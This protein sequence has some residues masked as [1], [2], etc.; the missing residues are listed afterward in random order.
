M[1]NDYKIPQSPDYS[2]DFQENFMYQANPEYI[3]REIAGEYILV[4]TG[5]ELEN[6]NGLAAVNETG[7][8]LWKLLNEK[9]TFSEIVECFQKEFELTREESWNDVSEFM[10]LAVKGR[11]ILKCS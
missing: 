11:V 4:P 3:M 8:F 5:A 9:K 1:K 6:F 7:V 10:D 2:V